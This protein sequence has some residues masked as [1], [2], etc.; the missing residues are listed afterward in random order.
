MN[1][2]PSFPLWPMVVS[3]EPYLLGPVYFPGV[4]WSLLV[5][6][7]QSLIVKLSRTMSAGYT[8]VG[9]NWLWWE[10]LQP[11]KSGSATNQGVPT[12]ERWLHVYHHITSTGLLGLGPMMVFVFFLVLGEAV[13]FLI[14]APG[15]LWLLDRTT[16][17]ELV[18]AIATS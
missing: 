17:G 4:C 18:L 10:Y 13:F 6:S 7:S 5:L 3:S 1:N 2:L 8:L 12:P 16:C 9:W 15:P 14:W 11:R